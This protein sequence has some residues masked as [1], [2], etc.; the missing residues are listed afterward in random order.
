MIDPCG[1]EYLIIWL[2]EKS[3]SIDTL[4]Y[5]ISEVGRKPWFNHVLDAKFWFQSVQQDV[6]I[7]SI[8]GSRHVKK[9]HEDSFVIIKGAEEIIFNFK[10]GSFWTVVTLVRRLK[11]LTKVIAVHMIHNLTWSCL[12]NDFGKKWQVGHR[13]IVLKRVSVSVTLLNHRCN[14]GLFKS[15]R[16]SAGGKR[17][18]NDLSDWGKQDSFW[19]ARMELYPRNKICL[20]IV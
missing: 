2:S 13:S 6:M 19:Q 20:E 5:A 14:D 1:K 7:D 15:W 12:L 8:E 3:P 9:D 10:E 18:I 4:S 11:G 17:S 16:E